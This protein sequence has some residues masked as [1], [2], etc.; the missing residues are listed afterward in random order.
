MRCVPHLGRL[1]LAGGLVC[2]SFAPAALADTVVL[3]NGRR[4]VAAAVSV[5]DGKVS[6]E[7]SAGQVT[8]PESIVAR[9]EKDDAGAI[10]DAAPNPAA[11]NLSITRPRVA[12]LDGA[13]L[14][15]SVV[16]DGAID[17]DALARLDAAASGGAPEAVAR[18]AAAESAASEFDFDHGNLGGAL[19]HS[20]R[21]LELEPA[22]LTLLLNVAYLH[23]RRSENTAALDCLERA[24]RIAPDSP[25]VA[26]LTGWAQYG[27]NRLR[28]AVQAWKRAQQLRPDPEVAR[29]LEKAERDLQTE[30]NFHEGQSA[31]FILRYYGGAAP[32]LAREILSQLEQDFLSISYILDYTPP[33]P[34]GVVLYTNRTFEDITRAPHWASALNDGRIRLPVQGL[35][36]MTPDLARVLRHELTHSFIAQKTQG[37]CPVWL[38]E[39]VAQWV[40]GR[41][42]GSAAPLLVTLYDHHEEPSLAALEGSWMNLPRDFAA[43]A[44]GWSLAVVENVVQSGGPVDVQRLLDRIAEGSSTEDAVRSTLRMSYADLSRST[45]EYLRRTYLH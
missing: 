29:A 9:V 11:A 34:I 16:H 15:A 28:L 38:Q 43:V 10:V 23:L 35:T 32:A 5:K 40:E 17:S 27:L 22:E 31:H 8:L 4:I 33:E 26:K 45:A 36:A 25:D 18:A 20:Q 44:Y 6:C 41:R 24:Q 2:A 21:A 19:A 12:P 7:T 37:R 1:L 30:Q 42:A 13:G 14:A 39:G 3:K